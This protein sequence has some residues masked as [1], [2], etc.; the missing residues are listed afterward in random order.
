MSGKKRKSLY[1]G[2]I[3]L[4]LISLLYLFSGA[5]FTYLGEFLVFD[6]KPAFSDAV[7]VLNTGMEYYPRL[8]EASVLYKQGFSDRVVI[9]GNRKTNALRNL[10]RKGFKPCCP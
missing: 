4:A 8:V 10:E 9:N 7:V 3:V 6:E 1:P 5:I 2:L